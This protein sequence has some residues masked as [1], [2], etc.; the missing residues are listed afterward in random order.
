MHNPDLRA[1]SG[2]RAYDGHPLTAQIWVVVT[3]LQRAYCQAR[4]QGGTL[5]EYIRH[6]LRQDMEANPVTWTPTLT[7]RRGAYRDRSGHKSA[8]PRSG[9]MSHY[10]TPMEMGHRLSLVVTSAMHAHLLAW[11]EQRGGNGVSDYVRD[12]IVAEMERY[13]LPACASDG[14][15]LRPADPPASSH[16]E[17]RAS[18]SAEGL[19][20]SR[21]RAA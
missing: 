14:E 19:I 5:S 16:R 1:S 11:S 2:R 21:Q 15:R 13:P 10:E 7:E 9:R 3:P 4:A 17:K 18:G 8:D 20:P 12:L 6:L